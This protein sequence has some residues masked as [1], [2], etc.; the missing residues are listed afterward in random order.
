VAWLVKEEETNS[1]ND[2]TVGWYEVQL[3]DLKRRGM[4]GK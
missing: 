2:G 4:A 3:E 1:S